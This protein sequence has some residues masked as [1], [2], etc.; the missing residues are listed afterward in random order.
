MRRRN[1]SRRRIAL[2][3]VAAVAGTAAFFAY[4]GIEAA[5]NM[6]V[7]MQDSTV[8]SKDDQMTKYDATIQFRNTSFV[9]LTI[10]DT[11]YNINID[12][13]YLGTGKIESF[14]IGP[15]STMLVSSEFI[16]NNTT[17]DRY[18]G[19][20]PHERTQLTGT[21]NY[22]LYLTAFD[23]PINYNPT[24]DQVQKFTK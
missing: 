10:G 19:E 14:V 6:D 2:I 13:D 22:N 23:V 20:I 21:S 15:Y 17:L 4:F 12:G 24:A 9:P 8:L 5:K 16:A 3:A 11:T 7:S 18:G 1:L